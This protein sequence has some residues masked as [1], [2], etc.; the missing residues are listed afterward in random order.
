MGTGRYKER[1]RPMLTWRRMIENVRNQAGWVS[2][3]E[4]RSAATEMGNRLRALC[5]N[6]HKEVIHFKY[7]DN[8]NY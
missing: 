1:G 5:A 2:W 8:M 6:R 4:V 3:S 7:H